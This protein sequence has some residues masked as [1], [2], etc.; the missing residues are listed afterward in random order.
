LADNADNNFWREYLR[1]LAPILIA[2]GVCV[3]LPLEPWWRIAVVALLIWTGAQLL[4]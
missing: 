3:G 4:L 1:R 2:A